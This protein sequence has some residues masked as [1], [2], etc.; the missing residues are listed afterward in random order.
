MLIKMARL[1]Q[2]WLM[3]HLQH[4]KTFWQNNV[5]ESVHT[6]EISKEC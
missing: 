2:E 6:L 5:Q 1:E 3:Q 4:L